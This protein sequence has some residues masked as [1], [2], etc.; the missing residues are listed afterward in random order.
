MTNVIR[1]VESRTKPSPKA[2]Y[3]AVDV[4]AAD[5]RVATTQ[6]SGGEIDYE[7]TSRLAL[8]MALALLRDGDDLP[9]A[10]TGGVW[11]PAA[12]WGD[13]LLARLEAI[14]MGVRVAAPNETA[15]T[16]MRQ[17]AARYKGEYR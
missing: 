12:G 5:R 9:A 14:G 4:E 7:D 13:A 16:I 11:S 8:E 15:A 1:A 2:I 6:I 10:R 3:T 17:T